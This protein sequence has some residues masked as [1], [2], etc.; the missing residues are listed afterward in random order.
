MNFFIDEKTNI[1][2]S[3]LPVC[4]VY[5]KLI[6]HC[7]LHLTLMPL[8]NLSFVKYTIEKIFRN[9]KKV[10]FTYRSFAKKVSL[11]R[12][13]YKVPELYVLPIKEVTTQKSAIL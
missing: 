8:K 7:F 9:R 12:S 1:H 6:L 11:M 13:N 4:Y 2:S 10:N 5:Y 3:R